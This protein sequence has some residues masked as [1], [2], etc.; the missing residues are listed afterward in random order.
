VSAAF[1]RA[2]E[3]DELKLA[4]LFIIELADGT[5]YRYTT[6]QTDLVWDLAGNTYSAAMPIQRSETTSKHSGEFDDVQ[7]ALG[8]ITGPFFDK[9]Y[10]GILEGVKITVKRIRWDITYAADEEITVF[11]GYADATF[12]RQVLNLTCRPI[13]SSLNIIVPAHQYQDSCN[14][15]LFDDGCTLVRADYAYSGTATGG[16]YTT[17][18]DTTRGAVYKVNFDAVTGAIAR[19]ET[20]VGGTG[21]G[22]GVVVQI[23]YLTASTG[24]VWYAQRTGVQFIDNEIVAHGAHNIT[25]SGTPAI[26]NTFYEL[27]EL[28][29]T[30]GDNSGQRRQ[31]YAD[32][33][34]AVTVA[35]GFAA[36]IS[37][38]I[39]YKLYPGDDRMALTCRDKFNNAVNFRG[40][41]YIPKPE[42]VVWR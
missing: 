8:N 40:F 7:V 35:W 25:L 27:G 15:A 9:A 22:T 24:T 33:S 41:P 39:T 17:L 29:I 6:H 30:N 10:R 23:V 16:T 3:S 26:D 32:A 31:V 18:E 4:E 5:I 20:I 12:N 1:Q 19:A 14:Y 38:G 13:L 42:D 28:E 21:A 34:G 2:L 11:E 37:N 36:P